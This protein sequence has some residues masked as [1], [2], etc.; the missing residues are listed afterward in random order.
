MKFIATFMGL[1]LKLFQKFMI[2]IVLEN[3]YKLWVY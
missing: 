3:I 2:V 1:A